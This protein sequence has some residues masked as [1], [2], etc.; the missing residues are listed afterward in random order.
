MMR[1]KYKDQQD[2][3]ERTISIRL[4]QAEYDWIKEQTIKQDQTASHIVRQWV[5]PHLFKD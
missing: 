1:T 4:K 3:K 2:R 5:T